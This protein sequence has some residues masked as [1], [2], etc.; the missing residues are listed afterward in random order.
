MSAEDIFG[1]RVTAP[2]DE[3]RARARAV[4]LESAAN[5]LKRTILSLEPGET[6]EIHRNAD[7]AHALITVARYSVTDEPET[8]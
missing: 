6:L 1:D 8:V 4:R 2:N 7:D 3:L 5:E